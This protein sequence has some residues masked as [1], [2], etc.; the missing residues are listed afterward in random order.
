MLEARRALGQGAGEAPEPNHWLHSPNELGRQLPGEMCRGRLTPGDEG[1]LWRFGPF[2]SPGGASAKLSF[3]VESAKPLKVLASQVRRGRI[4]SACEGAAA[5][6]RVFDLEPGDQVLLLLEADGCLDYRIW[7]EAASS[8]AWQLSQELTAQEKVQL[9]ARELGVGRFETRAGELILQR[10]AGADPRR[11]KELGLQ[12]IASGGDVELWRSPRLALLASGVQRFWEEAE[13]LRK[14]RL[15]GTGYENVSPNFAIPRSALAGLPQAAFAGGQGPSKVPNDPDYASQQWNLPMVGF[16]RAWAEIRGDQRLRIAFMDTGILSD[17][18]DLKSRISPYGYDFISDPKVANDGDGVDADPSEP[19]VLGPITLFHGTYVAAV[20]CA[21]TD[22]ALGMAGGTWASELMMLRVFGP[23]PGSSY[24]LVQA[25]RYCAGLSN[26]SGRV[27]K[28]AQRP[29]VLNL[30]FATTTITPAEIAAIR[31]CAKAG[32][33]IFAAVGND[34]WVDRPTYPAALPEVMGVG[35]VGPNKNKTSY[36][37]VGHF[38]DLVAPGGTTFGGSGGVYSAWGGEF[39]PGQFRFVY[40]TFRGTS[41]A[42]PHVSAAAALLRAVQPELSFAAGR[43]VLMQSAEDLGPVGRDKSY[44]AGLLQVHR[45][46]AEATK[47]IHRIRTRPHVLDFGSSKNSLVA[48][49]QS[50]GLFG[51]SSLSVGKISSPAIRASLDSAQA[52]SKLRLSLDRKGLPVAAYE[53]T[54]ELRDVHVQRQVPVRFSLP[55]PAPK[56]ATEIR[57]L[58]GKTIMYRTD[59]DAMGRFVLPA[60]RYGTYVMEMG[61]DQNGNGVL[62]DSQEWYL[63]WSFVV[64]PQGTPPPNGTLVPWVK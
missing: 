30:S 8:P 55:I 10:G 46:V 17:H 44:G 2:V 14:I 62:G 45:A 47:T 58:Q 61:V 41:V 50:A 23:Y 33:W 22:N 13:L 59:C 40:S 12:R 64:G 36:S 32:I 39:S 20:A 49:V 15:A 38:V 16:D 63:R 21:A 52:P 51:L 31:A 3:C 27:L 53:E 24:D 11:L 60:V 4:L 5:S 37:N 57:L 54:V 29:H 28:A 48:D 9:F 25:Y 26:V 56:R 18:P 43:K 19:R 6:S 7:A 1:D 42:T 35:A 34:S